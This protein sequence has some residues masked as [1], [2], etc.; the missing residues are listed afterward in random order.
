MHVID[1][2][3]V[4]RLLTP[5]VARE[6]MHAAFLA[7]ARGDAANPVR[8]VA[9]VP[10]GW[11]A[12]MPAFVETDGIRGLGAKLVAA[13]P[14]NAAHGK[15]THKATIALF[16]PNDGELL[17]LVA[18][19]TI[20][21]RRT[22]AASVVA[23]KRLAAKPA[24]RYAILG[25]GV[26]GRAH[27]EAFADAG[28]VRSLAVWS[29]DPAKAEALAKHARFLGISDARVASSPAMAVA[30]ADVVVTATGTS[31]PLIAAGDVLHGSHVNAVGSCVPQRRELA[32]DL[33]SRALVYVDSRDAALQESGDVLLAM[34]DIG[35]TDLIAG[36]LGEMLAAPERDARAGNPTV[37]KSLGLGIED[38]ICA[39]YVLSRSVAPV[40]AG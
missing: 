40:V 13:F 4:S 12:A 26:Q 25:A 31:E 39:A 17:A 9:A 15:A 19:D 35:R 1:E 11:F 32:A 20:T 34:R 21:E 8:A 3:A 16:D 23:T 18:G 27:L 28:L 38:V 30:E 36:E 7:A 37:F 6:L 29:R 22:A 14:G 2:T 5:A 33:L 10:S 24:G